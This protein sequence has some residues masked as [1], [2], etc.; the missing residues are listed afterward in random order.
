MFIYLIFI[1]NNWA[2]AARDPCVLYERSKYNYIFVVYENIDYVYSLF[3][4]MSKKSQKGF[5]RGFSHERLSPARGRGL[6]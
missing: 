3:L 4:F 2:R 5:F 1:S 6:T